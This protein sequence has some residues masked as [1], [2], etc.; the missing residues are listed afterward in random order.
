MNHRLLRIPVIAVMLLCA[1]CASHLPGNASQFRLRT[2][3]LLFQDL[4]G[5]PLCDAIEKVTQGANGAKLSHVGMVMRVDGA[6]VTVVEAV[7]AGV[8][9][10]PLS[11]FLARSHD[12][13]GRPK[14]I[15]GRLS[16]AY[17]RLI[18]GALREAKRFEGLPYDSRFAIGDDAFY[19]SELIYE[20]FRLAN[21][22]NPVFQLGP[23][24]FKDPDTGKTF[25]AW[26]DY[27]A[28]LNAVIPEGE[29]G[30]N[31]GGLSRS[32]KV[33]IVYVYGAPDGWRRP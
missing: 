26:T 25:P 31:P 9:E 17:R 3:D 14:V 29:P 4:D 32:S 10:T 11:D 24:T 20:V 12:A 13:N 22:G 23:M 21:G 27:Y 2:G 16:P 18:P 7:S 19:C 8:R 28:K 33:D 6:G 30:L 1:A 5:S 15:V